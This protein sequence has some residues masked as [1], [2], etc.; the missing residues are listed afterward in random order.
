[1]SHDA[2]WLRGSVRKNQKVTL[3]DHVPLHFH[4]KDVGLLKAGVCWSWRATGRDFELYVRKP[5]NIW[6]AQLNHITVKEC[7]IA[8]KAGID[9]THPQGQALKGEHPPNFIQYHPSAI[10]L[11]PIGKASTAFLICLVTPA[12][13]VVLNRTS[14][15]VDADIA[16]QIDPPLTGDIS[17]GLVRERRHLGIRQG[18]KQGRKEQAKPGS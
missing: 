12:K 17:Q 16:R 9:R 14:H 3:H 8:T 6:Q 4:R 10:L 15:F 5:D 7:S 11:Q 2:S 18:G 13:V 1:T